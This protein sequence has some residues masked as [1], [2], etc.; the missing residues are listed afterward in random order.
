MSGENELNAVAEPVGRA[1]EWVVI[2]LASGDPIG[3]A[4]AKLEPSI[5]NYRKLAAMIAGA[6]LFV[7]EEKDALM[8]DEAHDAV[9]QA[10]SDF[11][12]DH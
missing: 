6:S 9:T 12:H 5:E 8:L 2:Q 7:T 4:L 1:P 3:P 11:V 10:W